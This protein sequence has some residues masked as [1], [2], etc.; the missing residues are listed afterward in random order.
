MQLFHPWYRYWHH[1]FGD[2]VDQ[3]AKGGIFLRWSPDYSEWPNCS[4]S[5]KDVF[6]LQAGKLVLER[7]ITKMITKGPLFLCACVWC[8]FTDYAK[9]E[10]EAILYPFQLLNLIFLP[11]SIPA[12]RVSDRF[13]GSGMTA[14]KVLAGGPPIKMETLSG[15]FCLIAF[16]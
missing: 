16:S 9:S 7:V 11:A 13:S 8:Y 3:V 12:K 14:A 15:L 1:R 2:I 10:S 6:D 4:V 5:V